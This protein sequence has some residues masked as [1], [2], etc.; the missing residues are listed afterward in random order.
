[1]EVKFKYKDIYLTINEEVISKLNSY[2]Q[3]HRDLPESGGLLI[4]RTNIN[5]NTKI[6]DITNPQQN[7]IQKRCFF[8]RRDFQ[9]KKL[10]FEA[11][12]KCLYFKGNWHTHPQS[13]PSPSWIDLITWKNTLKKSKT[14]GSLYAFF[15]I[16]GIVE[17]RIWIGK[18]N[19]NEI[20]EM[21]LIK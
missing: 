18:I 12:E 14:G 9:H 6:I 8:V 10:L 13:I 20:N 11:N 4:G 16:V 7:D 19:T 5:G 2:K 3:S 15:I 17:I 1:M 21:T